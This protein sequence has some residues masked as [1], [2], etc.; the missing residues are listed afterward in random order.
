MPMPDGTDFYQRTLTDVGAA[1]P[2]RAQGGL[3]L[4]LPPKYQGAFPAYYA[5]RS[6]TYNVLLFFRARC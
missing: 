5:F 3:Y 6:A 1:G 4:L 2:D